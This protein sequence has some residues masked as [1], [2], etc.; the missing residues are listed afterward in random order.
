MTIT[1]RQKIAT[2]RRRALRPQRINPAIG[3]GRCDGE[4]CGLITFVADLTELRRATDPPSTKL[5]TTCLEARHEQRERRATKRWS[6][7][8]LMSLADVTSEAVERVL[9]ATR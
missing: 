1:E 5:C 4:G 2:D 6:T 9:E 8:S 3:M 7:A